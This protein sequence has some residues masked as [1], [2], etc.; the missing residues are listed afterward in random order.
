MPQAI[1]TW[2]TDGSSFLHEGDRRAGYAIV[3]NMKVVEA[4]APPRH[5]TNQQAKLIALTHAFH[6]AQGQSLNFY[7]GSKYAFHILLFHTAI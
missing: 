3:S 1:Y 2:Y 6:L 4:Q 5:T 7:T